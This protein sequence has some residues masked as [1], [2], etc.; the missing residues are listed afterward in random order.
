MIGRKIFAFI[1]SIMVIVS[2]A[3]ISVSANNHFDTWF[4]FP[5]TNGESETVLRQKEDDSSSYMKPTYISCS[6]YNV[7]VQGADSGQVDAVRY[8][9]ANGHYYSIYY[10]YTEYFLRNYVYE[11]GHSYAGIHATREYPSGIAQ[12]WWSPDSV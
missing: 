5:F 4:S 2:V 3:S 8:D 7:Y 11:W 6:Y 10:A 9:C 12:G 1:L